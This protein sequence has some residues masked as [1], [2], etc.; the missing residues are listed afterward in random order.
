MK[1]IRLQADNPADIAK[2]GEILRQGGLVGI[3]TETVYGLAAD[4]LN[5][6]AVA[7]IFKAKGRPMDNPLIVHI[8]DISQWKQL[9]REIPENAKK[10]AQA[11]WPGPMTI[12]LPKANCIPDEVSAGLETV[13][14]RFPVHP[15]AQ[16]VIQAAG[17]PLAA[18]SGNLSGK[19]SPTTAHT[20]LEDMDGRIDAV[21]DGGPCQVGVES[22]VV[23]LAC[24]PPRLLRPGG[25]TLEQLRQVLGEVV[26]DDA[27]LNPLKEGEHPASPGMKYKHYAPK[28]NVLIV[29]GPY[30]SYCTYVNSHKGPG[31]AAMCYNGEG[32]RLEVPAVC[33]GGKEDYSEQ[34]REVFEALRKLDELGAKTV[35]A[36]C[37]EPEGVGLAVYNRLIRAAGFEVVHVD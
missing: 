22:T 6:E 25:I 8:A 16:A 29:D 33:Y 37:P 10:L 21:V 2:A 19:P 13:G 3:P 26:M 20:M 24:N 5:G 9:V 34:A 1:T 28:A 17:T 14:V 4:A 27:V 11:Y 35:Y 32:S 15:A 30:E 31:V 18:P 12:I 7:K 36:R 23:S